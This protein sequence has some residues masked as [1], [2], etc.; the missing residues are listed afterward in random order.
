MFGAKKGLS[1]VITNVLIILLVLIAISLVWFF[2]SGTIRT[3]AEQTSG[4][5][6]C[7]TVSVEPV[8][9]STGGTSTIIVKRNVGSGALF[10]IKFVVSSGGIST[11]YDGNSATAQGLVELETAIFTLTGPVAAG[12]TIAVA[13]VV[14]DAKTSKTCPVS[15]VKVTCT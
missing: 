3:G 11:V 9:C 7:I 10:G 15:P 1:D 12:N 5:A 8:S 4:A 2:V 6:D 13:P 14:G